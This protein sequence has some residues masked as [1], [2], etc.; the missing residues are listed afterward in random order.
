MAILTH[1]HGIVLVPECSSKEAE[2]LIAGN[3]QLSLAEAIELRVSS[4]FNDEPWT[5]ELMTRNYVMYSQSRRPTHIGELKMAKPIL[6]EGADE[7]ELWLSGQVGKAFRDIYEPN[8]PRERLTVPIQDYSRM[9]SF[10][11]DLPLNLTKDYASKL[12]EL[13]MGAGDIYVLR[14]EDVREQVIPFLRRVRLRKFRNGNSNGGSIACD[15]YH[16]FSLKVPNPKT[17]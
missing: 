16:S 5:S 7:R 3:N 1:H 15:A 10:F 14:E 12:K 9:L 11:F 17:L 4:G 8:L 6:R 13:G 2:S